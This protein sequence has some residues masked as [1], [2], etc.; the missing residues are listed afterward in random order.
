MSLPEIIIANNRRKVA[1]I[2]QDMLD[3]RISI[4]A[5]ARQ[6]SALCGGHVGFD[7]SDPDFRTFIGIDSETN[8]LPVGQT[9]QH[10][11]PD[12]LAKRDEEI[13]RCE[14]LYRDSAHEAASHLVARFEYE[15]PPAG[16][17]DYYTPNT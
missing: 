3:G 10:W 6:I 12:A 8:D 17:Y 14:A 11:S 9:R 4:I 15:K 13:A 16:A 5:S 7:E 1:R 2:A